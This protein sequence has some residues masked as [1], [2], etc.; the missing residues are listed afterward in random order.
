MEIFYL[1]KQEVL[2]SID[3]KSLESFWDGRECAC[4]DKYFEHVLGL[5]LTKFVAKHIYGVKNL[6]IELRGKKP[7]FMSGGIHFSISHSNDIVLV[8]FNNAEIGADVEFMCPRNYK[9]IMQ[10][11]GENNPNPSRIDFYKFW[12]VH[13]AEIKLNKNVRSL[14][15]TFLGDDYI[16]SCVS[17]NVLVTN[18]S[19]KNLTISS[20]NQNINLLEEFAYPTNIKIKSVD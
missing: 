14:F 3:K 15:S 16:V 9:G 1:K 5:F 11:Y 6:N 17:S 8:A 18:F 19:I 10:R 7:Y 12:T 2:N 4:E 13:E 20:T